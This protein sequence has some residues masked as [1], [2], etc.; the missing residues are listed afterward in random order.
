MDSPGAGSYLGSA[1]A[2][3]VGFLVPLGKGQYRLLPPLWSV[4]AYA[5]WHAAAADGS[6]HYP[7]ATLMRGWGGATNLMIRT[8]AAFC[9]NFP[10]T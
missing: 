10:R 6:S 4:G 7:E 9:C 2:P 1:D 3:G 8:A 5:D